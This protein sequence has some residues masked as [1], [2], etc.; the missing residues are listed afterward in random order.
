V[1]H[2]CD[3]SAVGLLPP[4]G[5]FLWALPYSFHHKS[6]KLKDSEVELLAGDIPGVFCNSL[7]KKLCYTSQYPLMDKCYRGWNTP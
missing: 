1:P 7:I 6:V 3:A 4:R 5:F 2:F